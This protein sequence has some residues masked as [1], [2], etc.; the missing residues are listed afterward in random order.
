M[1]DVAVSGPGQQLLNDN[2]RLFIFAFTELMMS[3]MPSRID[4]VEGRPILVVECASYSVMI[5]D[6][7]RVIDT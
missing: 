7:N 4:E 2:S 5:I 3:N 1:A 6:G